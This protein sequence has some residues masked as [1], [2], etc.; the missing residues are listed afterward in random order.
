MINLLERREFGPMR[1]WGLLEC[2]ALNS[3]KAVGAIS[4]QGIAAEYVRMHREG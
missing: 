1:G 3:G 2:P 4:C